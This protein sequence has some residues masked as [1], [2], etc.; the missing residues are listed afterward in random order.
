MPF[1]GK[2]AD[3]LPADN[4]SRRAQPAAGGDFPLYTKGK[5]PFIWAFVPLFHQD[6]RLQFALATQSGQI[7]SIL[8]EFVCNAVLPKFYLA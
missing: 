5:L 4:R 7:G 1:V 6:F 3:C 2:P 8:S